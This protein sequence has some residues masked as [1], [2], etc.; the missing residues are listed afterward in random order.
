ME[1]NKIESPA[2]SPPRQKSY[3]LQTAIEYLTT[4][5]AS[6]IIITIVIAVIGLFLL[7]GNGGKT[8]TNSQST[9][10]ISPQLNCQELSISSNSGMTYALLLFTNNLGTTITFPQNGI[11]IFPTSSQTS[12]KGMCFPEPAPEGAPVMCNVTLSGYSTALGT[13]LEP[14]FQV[15]Y[16][17]CSNGQ[18]ST[19]N[20]TGSSTT[21]VSSNIPLA[22]VQLFTNPSIGKVSVNGVPYS[23]GTTASFIGGSI[24]NIFGSMPGSTYSFEGWEYSG[25]ASVANILTNPGKAFATAP[26]T[27]TAEFICYY[28]TYTSA[29]GGGTESSNPLSTGHCTAN[30]FLPY[31]TGVNTIATPDPGDFFS[32]WSGS[33]TNSYS[34]T[35]NPGLVSEM[36]GN[37]IETATY[38]A[39]VTIEENPSSAANSWGACFSY[40]NPVGYTFSTP[41][42]TCAGPAPSGGGSSVT[43]Q[44]PIGSNIVYLCTGPWN[45]FSYQYNFISWSD[46]L[47]STT[48]CNPS[49][50]IAIPVNGPTTLIANYQSATTSPP[51]CYSLSLNVNPAGVGTVSTSPGNSPGCPSGWY[52]PDA[53]V[54]I[55]TAQTNGLYT[56]DAWSATGGDNFYSN[57]NAGY[58]S[59]QCADARPCVYEAGATSTTIYIE[60]NTIETANY[61][62]PVTFSV[63]I[64]PSGTG[65]DP[66]KYWEVCAT[67]SYYGSGSSG[68]ICTGSGASGPTS[69]QVPVG[70]TV[71]YVYTA[72]QNTGTA[73]WA[74]ATTYGN[75][76]F[77]GWSG[78]ASGTTESYDPGYTVQPNTNAAVNAGFEP[79]LSVQ[80]GP[81]TTARTQGG[82]SDANGNNWACYAEG[83]N[84]GLVMKAFG[85]DIDNNILGQPYAWYDGYSDGDYNI[86]EANSGST[87]AV[88]HCGA[89]SGD[90]PMGYPPPGTA[91]SFAD[92]SNIYPNGL[93]S[94]STTLNEPEIAYAD[95]YPCFAAVVGFGS[96]GEEV[97]VSGGSLTSGGDYACT[98][99]GTTATVTANPEGGTFNGWNCYVNSPANGDTCSSA[100][101]TSTSWTITSPTLEVGFS[102]P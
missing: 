77:G 41:V 20:T 96:G 3:K 57:G 39:P 6:L 62:N 94:V 83:T 14:R 90:A 16:N 18:C 73:S 102:T 84:M 17:V 12:Y 52:T 67:D 26:G 71:N 81:H 47:S 2:H 45:A 68:E 37:I 15:S 65:D 69:E 56:W 9:C 33:G 51:L 54:E 61:Y 63:G 85:S 92:S 25:G 75:W 50:S 38:N 7:T 64:G 27:I 40:T 19:Y 95:F 22:E 43:V 53:Q 48:E 10:Y 99:Y 74:G 97:Q 70:S 31:T 98:P 46:A 42:Q 35:N 29:Y 100:S 87:I 21:Y 32:F 86:V 89:G 58:A 4:F 5:G 79:C 13:Q 80:E 36:V 91:S 24:Y 11:T 66:S 78:A 60:G 1:E 93:C 88:E 76:A 8:G 59:P 55:S 72:G 23:S 82:F 44:V 28:I 34:G 49:G 30:S 101:S